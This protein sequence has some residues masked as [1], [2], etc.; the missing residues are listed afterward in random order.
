MSKHCDEF[1]N[2]TINR[3]T[4]IFCLELDHILPHPDLETAIN[5]KTP[6]L[7]TLEKILGGSGAHCIFNIVVSKVSKLLPKFVT[8]R[9]I[10]FLLGW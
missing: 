4:D 7:L 1:H 3:N 10:D 2:G 6:H 5:F 9:H 8:Y